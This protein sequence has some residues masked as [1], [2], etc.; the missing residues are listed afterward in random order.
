LQNKSYSINPAD[1]KSAISEEMDFYLQFHTYTPE[2]D[3]IVVKIIHR[4]LEKYD[5]LYIK[6]TILSVTKELINNSIKANLKRFYFRL[7]NLDIDKMEDYRKG[8]ETFKIDTYQSEDHKIIEDLKDSN[9]VVRA[10]FKTSEEHIHINIINNIPIL[11]AELNKINARVQ[12]AYKYHDISDAFEDVLDDSEGA[13]LGLIMA[14]MLLK[15]TGLPSDSFKIYIKNNLTI[16]KLTIPKSLTKFESKIEITEEILKEIKEIPAFPS[17]IIEIQRI[18]NNPDATMKEIADHISM[19]PGLTTSILK[20]ANS[21]GYIT[22]KKI[23]SI[24][25]AAKI[26]GIRGINTLLVATGV[27]KIIDSKY[28]KFEAVWKDSFKRAFYAQ[29]IASQ[30]KQTKI[31]EFAYLSALL[32]DIG[33]IVMLSI[34]PQLISKLKSKTGLNGINDTDLLEEIGLGLSHSSIGAMI[35]KKWKFHEA[36]I[37]AIELHHR[38]HLAPEK[39]TQLIYIVYLSYIYIEI[40][41][42]KF[43]FEIA[44]EDV[45]NFFN[46]TE[47]STFQNLHNVLKESYNERLV[48]SPE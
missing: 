40:E 13:G 29:K 9:L 28:K 17:N 45:L 22:S 39:Y 46:L 7:K 43:R 8:M 18:C 26:I 12:K 14:M 1:F 21:A 23:E 3:S 5:I 36:L 33:K 25:E 20:L 41:N 32:S 44:D 37:S 35:C 4:Y 48:L 42:N 34:N 30:L 10:S 6:D 16:S 27:H 19:D 15:N 24:E 31:S 38:P 2:V 11:E 47:K